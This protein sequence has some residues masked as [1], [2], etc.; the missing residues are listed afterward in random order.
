V[1]LIDRWVLLNLVVVLAVDATVVVVLGPTAFLFLLAS[2]F[3]SIGLHPLGARWIQRHYTLDEGQETFS[4]YGP[5]NVLALNVGYHNEHHD[6]PSVPWNGL[7]AVRRT[8]PE[9]YRGLEAYTSWTRLLV[10]F[11]RDPDLTLYSRLTRVERNGRTLDADPAP[12]LA[13]MASGP[14]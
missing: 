2:L 10:R 9:W 5:A 11:L 4:Y 12:D 8:A 6:F 13:P 1:P 3:F 14:P 7:P